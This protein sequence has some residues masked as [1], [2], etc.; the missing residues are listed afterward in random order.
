LFLKLNSIV[1]DALVLP[2]ISIIRAITFANIIVVPSPVFLIE[3]I[4]LDYAG[5]SRR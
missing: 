1:A 5:A 2:H 3:Q 4:R